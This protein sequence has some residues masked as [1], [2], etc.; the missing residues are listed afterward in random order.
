MRKILSDNCIFCEIV[1]GRSP[2]SVVF[3]DNQAMCFMTLRPT[4]PGECMVIP[5][6]HIDHFTDVPD[7]LASHI[8]IIAQRVARK[9][10]SSFVSKRIGMVIHG[11][12]VSHA[13]LILLPQHDITD[14]TSGRF[15]KIEDGKIVYDH[16][17]IAMFD[18]EVLDEH[19]ARLRIDNLD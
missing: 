3:A 1:A 18:R 8:M 19:A 11:F 6:E 7:D 14:I 12:G 17:Q 16:K 9:M 15:A 13:H 10:R 2:A 4:R 5:K